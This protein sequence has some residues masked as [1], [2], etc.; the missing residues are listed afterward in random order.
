M[1]CSR[2]PP[3]ARSAA[4]S[5]EGTSGPRSSSVV[6]AMTN[7]QRAA[8]WP[9]E[10]SAAGGSAAAIVSGACRS[11]DDKGGS[12]SS[13]SVASSSRRSMDGVSAGWTTA[14]QPSGSCCD[15]ASPATIAAKVAGVC[16]SAT[17]RS[18][19]RV[20]VRLTEAAVDCSAPS[21]ARSRR[22]PPRRAA[23]GVAVMMSG[24]TS[25]GC[26]RESTALVGTATMVSGATML[27]GEL[28]QR[29][30]ERRVVE[31]P[32]AARREPRLHDRC[33]ARRLR[34]RPRE[35]RQPR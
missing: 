3:C 28:R 30:L 1:N 8:M 15:E 20:T 31:P 10:T 4:S 33:P 35:R 9:S 24:A 13:S 23:P 34:V 22:A 14:F 11:Y 12:E 32:H 17:H 5:A 21:S 7:G 6:G 26:W 25:C 27:R 2:V 16:T 19:T 18:G 29:E